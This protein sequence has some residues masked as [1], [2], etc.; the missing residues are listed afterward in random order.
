[1]ENNLLS[2]K[3]P[4]DFSISVVVATL[5]RPDDLRVCLSHLA[6]QETNRAVEIIVVDNQPASGLTPP[7]VAEFTGVRLVVERRRGL[8]YARNKGFLASQGEIVIATD[9]DVIAPPGWLEKLLAPF[10][11][12]EVMVVTGNVLPWELETA[13]Q[14]LFEAYGGLGRGAE[15]RVADGEWFR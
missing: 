8:A 12:P 1:M 13:A 7:V 4:S 9:D 11:N 10:T 6:A 15:K 5:D 3:S 2:V 14:R